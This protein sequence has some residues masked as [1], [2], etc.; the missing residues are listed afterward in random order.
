MRPRKL[1]GSGAPPPLPA[2][3]EVATEAELR[4]EAANYVG[5]V[6][7]ARNY[8]KGWAKVFKAVLHL[9]AAAAGP[10]GSGKAK[11]AQR[12]GCWLLLAAALSGGGRHWRGRLARAAAGGRRALL[13]V[14]AYFY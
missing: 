3:R 9:G 4:L 10:D 1:T 14:V 2:A 12:C 5:V 13:C 8:D 11:K 6:F 7:V